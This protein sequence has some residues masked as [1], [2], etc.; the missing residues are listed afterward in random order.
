M[1]GTLVKI[2]I[3]YLVVFLTGCRIGASVF[4]G[5]DV[6]SASGTRHCFE[7]STCEFQVSDMNFTE[8]FT[9]QPRGGYEF[10]KW[11]AGDGF[12]CGDSTN[13][14]CTISA[15]GFEGNEIIEA[16]VESQKMI[17]IMPEFNCVIEVCP[18]RPDPNWRALDEAIVALEEAKMIVAAYVATNGGYP[19]SGVMFG[20]NTSTRQSNMLAYIDVTDSPVNRATFFISAAVFKSVWDASLERFDGE[21]S[22]FSLSG[23]TNADNS[24]T[25][26]C[27]PFSKNRVPTEIPEPYLPI[28]CRG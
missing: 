8:S 10:V 1:K 2:S 11:R 28:D 19:V 24:M 4:E 14:T 23:S 26:E 6:I 21:V 7:G 5:G 20:L 9:A 3:F 27:V 18:V 12:F 17:Y 15:V 22:F 13:P 25:W 16:I